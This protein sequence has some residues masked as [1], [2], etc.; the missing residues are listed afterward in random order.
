MRDRGQDVMSL[1]FEM[2]I[3]VLFFYLPACGVLGIVK[4]AFHRVLV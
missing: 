4:F 3:I 2:T 1:I